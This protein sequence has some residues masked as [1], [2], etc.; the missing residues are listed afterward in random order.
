MLGLGAQNFEIYYYQHRATALDMRQPHSQPL[1]LLA[2]LGFPGLALW[3]A[4]VALILG[5][6][7]FLRFGAAGRRAGR[8][9][10]ALTAAMITAV[11]SWFIHSSADW[12]WQLAAVSLPA[13]LL[14]GGLAGVDATHLAYP[15]RRRPRTLAIPVSV[16]E[17]GADESRAV[18]EPGGDAGALDRG[19]S[20]TP[21]DMRI[22]ASPEES[23]RSDTQSAGGGH[24]GNRARLALRLVRPMAVV[25]ATLAIISASLPYV[26][27]RFS[28]SASAAISTDPRTAFARAG[29]AAKLDPTSTAPYAVR[30]GVHA[31]AAAQAAPGSPGRA[32]ELMLAAQAW[33]EATQ[34]E[35]HGW[36]YHYQ[37]AQAYIA[38]RDA[39]GAAGGIQAAS[40]QDLDVQARAHL[41]EARRLNPLSPAV[42]ALGKGL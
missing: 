36:L 4:F 26:S 22:S 27:S 14:L 19:I 35:P 28:D 15:R 29:T 2:E 33:E 12:L 17:G 11:I 5:R 10:Q 42:A 3:V 38:A 31:A 20:N 25:L 23:A 9:N 34:V 39:A 37:A 13:M 32:L 18:A 21:S 7:A 40:V 1:Q 8:T 30:A 16:V 41:A 6:A 24:P